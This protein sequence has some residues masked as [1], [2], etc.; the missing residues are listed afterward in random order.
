VQTALLDS[1]LA[2]PYFARA[3]PKSTGRD[4]FN[5]N[6]L[7][8]H[9]EGNSY[10]PEDV[11]ATLCQLTINSIV[12]A[13]KPYSP[14]RLLV[15]GGGVHNPLLMKGLA[16]HLTQTMVE[17]TKV[18]GIDSAWVEATTFAWLAKRR[19]EN[20]PGNLPSVTGARQAV[21]LGGIYV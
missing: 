3:A 12:Q 7:S 13:V 10:Q 9:L 21:V 1:F 4:Y 6:W 19:L 5:L 11:Q 14:Q 2:D 18:H 8:P 16:T 20:L 17:S 15:C